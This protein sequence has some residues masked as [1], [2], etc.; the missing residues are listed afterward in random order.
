MRPATILVV[1]DNPVTRKMVRVTLASEGYTVLEAEDG[2]TAID[3]LVSHSPDLVLQDVVL[4]DLDGIELVQRLRALPN[5]SEIPIL[6]FTGLLS[7]ADHAQSVQAGFTDYLFK[8]V[9]PSRLLEVI[10]GYLAV[11]TGPKK[12]V[13]DGRLIIV[14]DD[15]PVQRKLI[16]L[17]LTSVGFRVTLAQDGEDALEAT[18]RTQPAAILSD[19]LMPRLDGFMLCLA[20]RQDRRLANTPVVLLSSIFVDE[21]D[22]QLALG[23]GANAFVLRTPGYEEAIEALLASLTGGMPPSPARTEGF[24]E[25]YVH[26]VVR[27][28]EAQARLNQSLTSRLALYETQLAIL[29]G[30]T[31]VARDAQAGLIETILREMLLRCLDAI[32]V[33]RGAI[34][35]TE[36]DGRLAPRVLVGYSA[37]M[38]QSARDFCGYPNLLQKA[39]DDGETVAFTSELLTGEDQL[40]DLLRKAGATSI[41]VSPL[42]LDTERLGALVLESA[43]AKLG[44]EWLAFVK[45]VG[46]QIGQVFGLARAVSDLHTLKVRLEQRVVEQTRELQESKDSLEMLIALSPSLIFKADVKDACVTYTSP[47]VERLLG[48]DTKEILGV[49]GFWADHVHPE[50][51][52]GF[53]AAATE[54]IKERAAQFEQEY[55]FQHKDGSYRWIHG[56]VRIQYDEAGEPTIAFGYSLD[57]TRRKAAQEDLKQAQLEADHA[58]KSKSEFLSRMSHELR[59]PLN[60]V[61]GF[62]QL[63]EMELASPKQREFLG[64]ILTGGR[65]LLDLINEVLDISRIEAGRLALSL[66]P[67]SAKGAIQE[68]LVLIAPLAAEE[69]VR[70][71]DRTA[72]NGH[73]FVLADH[74]RLK[75]V[76]LNLLANA[77]KYNH[78]QGLV[79]VSLEDVPGDRLQIRVADT[80]SGIPPEKLKRLFTPFD[81]LGAEQTAIEGT[82]LGLALSK[83]LVEMMGGTLGVASTVGQGSVFWVELAV[84]EGSEAR[85]KRAELAI[86]IEVELKRS[87]EAF[88]ILYVEDNLSNLELIQG[89]LAHRSEIQLIP[90]MQGQLGLD[91]ARQHRPDLIL[92]DLHL[93]DI[94]GDEVLRRLRDIPATLHVPVIVISADATPS[95]VQRLLAAGARAYLTKPLDVKKFFDVLDEILRKKSRGGQY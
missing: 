65:H 45:T 68:S 70:L 94:P 48:Y 84:T 91:L 17:H 28:L 60:A 31:E 33:S 59:T 10:R 90:A 21:E 79:A 7:V 54:A 27:Q 66:E 12:P 56:T 18:R 46:H 16:Q 1:E 50:D 49:P 13:G 6:A 19:V 9:D 81:R 77:I 53:K 43:R 2:R 69:G 67:V 55:R 76:L 82:G 74:Q 93:P 80:G 4:P 87:Q 15:D 39:V 3:L 36:P 26:R 30:L 44:D 22:R 57:V 83:R 20:V 47:N 75:Q 51:R 52:E 64:Y 58:N 29:A 63:L 78:A 41:L 40:T 25:V 5:G 86:P 34:Y 71:D 61:L 72:S 14:A 8:P 35:L 23:A 42:I 32:G 95:Q 85:S 73:Q 88:T 89:L 62:A 24:G 38:E 11:D 92:L 37:A